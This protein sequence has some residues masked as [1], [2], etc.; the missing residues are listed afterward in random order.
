MEAGKPQHNCPSRANWPMPDKLANCGQHHE[1]M[2]HHGK[3]A[4]HAK[5]EKHQNVPNTVDRFI[6]RTRIDDIWHVF[7][8]GTCA[9]GGRLIMRI[10]ARDPAA[11]RLLPCAAGGPGLE[12][13]N[14]ALSA[15]RP[16]LPRLRS[17]SA[18]KVML[19]VDFSACA[20]SRRDGGRELLLAP[21]AG[22]GGVV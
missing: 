12:S 14:D 13:S 5:M 3:M 9:S 1:K 4:H 7:C 2:A 21:F 20:A 17:L 19:E 18:A 15:K 11:P 8:S 16:R 10:R 6:Q 22:E